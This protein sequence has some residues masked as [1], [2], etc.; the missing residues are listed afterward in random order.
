[1]LR[2]L[3]N[4]KSKDEIEKLLALRAKYKKTHAVDHTAVSYLVHSNKALPKLTEEVVE[5]LPIEIVKDELQPNFVPRE[6][7]TNP[8]CYI[9]HLCLMHNIPIPS[10]FMYSAKEEST[11]FVNIYLYAHLFMKTN[12]ATCSI[13]HSAVLRGHTKLALYCLALNV[14][15]NA[16]D[17]EGRTP[18]MYA[19]LSGQIR[20][21]ELLLNCH[22]KYRHR[23]AADP[24]VCDAEGRTA[25]TYA[26]EP[27]V[28]AGVQLYPQRVD[29]VRLLIAHKASITVTDK[30]WMQNFEVCRVAKPSCSI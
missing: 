27:A 20:M 1:L 12:I 29:F 22:D 8:F 4:D 6:Q 11:K 30:V 14:D 10:M 5:K 28:V 15:V 23:Q 19:V 3:L 25:L 16:K 18:L 9:A 13:L 21:A 2:L 17:S 24:N 7:L 26:L